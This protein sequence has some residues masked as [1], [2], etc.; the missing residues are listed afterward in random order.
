MIE[1]SAFI[2]GICHPQRIK[3]LNESLNYLDK[4]NFPFK[5]KVLAIDEFGG[6][7]FPNEFKMELESR[8]WTILIDNHRSRTKS[9]DH[10]FNII[11]SDYIFYNED[12]VKATIPKIEDLTKIF[13]NTKV[14]NRECGMISLTLGGSSNHFPANEYGDLKEIKNNVLLQNNDYLIFRRLEEK[15]NDYFFEFPGLI[16]K[17]KLFKECHRIAKKFFVNEQIERGLTKAWFS[18]MLNDNYYKCSVA[19]NNIYEIIDTSP[20]DSTAKCRLLENLDENQGSSPFGGNHS[21][22]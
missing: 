18:S 9:M 15:K 13:N 2:M 16:I 5:Q 3:F 17:T 14:G 8:G 22:V 10:A 1:V 12:D 11:T 21:Y 4:Q 20:A 7:T 19:K 6:H